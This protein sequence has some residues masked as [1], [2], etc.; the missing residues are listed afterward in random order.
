MWSEPL[1]D[2][3][4]IFVGLLVRFPLPVQKRIYSELLFYFWSRPG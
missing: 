3:L 1:M 4:T 2:V